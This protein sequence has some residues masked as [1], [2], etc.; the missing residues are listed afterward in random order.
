MKRLHNTILL[1]ITDLAFIL[2]LLGIFSADGSYPER[3]L[4][5]MMLAL[6]WL[7]PFTFVNKERWM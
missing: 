2:L 5:I 4:M 1:L 6:L 3:S 7:I